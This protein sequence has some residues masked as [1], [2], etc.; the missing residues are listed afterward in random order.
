MTDRF[1]AAQPAPVEEPDQLAVAVLNAYR[2]DAPAAFAAPPV[3]RIV[4]TARR[5]SWVRTGVLV[6]AVLVVLGGPVLVVNAL[7]H[8]ERGGLGPGEIPRSAYSEAPGPGPS[9]DHIGPRP[10]GPVPVP[11]PGGSGRLD[12]A[13]FRTRLP[14]IVEAGG[15]TGQACPG[16][17]VVFHSD[18]MNAAAAT[19]GRTRYVIGGH[20]TMPDHYL[21]GATADLDGD[22]V[23]EIITTIACEPSGGRR[24]VNLYVLKRTGDGYRVLDV[25]FSDN[26]SFNTP[27]P[28]LYSFGITGRTLVI[29]LDDLGAQ[30]QPEPSKIPDG[31]PNNPRDVIMEWNGETFQPR[32]GKYRW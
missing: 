11:G 26:R 32:V 22:G 13:T 3:Q 18:G 10:S 9:A 24:T 14:A 31:R 21:P 2:A 15:G 4:R 20:P 6:I 30:P 25:P 27:R 1:G 23:N 5:R 12:L 7:G 17:D 19:L 8:H 29:T 28:I 16:G